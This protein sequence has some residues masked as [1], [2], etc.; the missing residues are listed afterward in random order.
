VPSRELPAEL[1]GVGQRIVDWFRL[2][3]GGDEPPPY[4]VYV[5][6]PDKEWQTRRGLGDLRTWLAAPGRGV[7]CV[8]VSLAGVFWQALEEGG[9]TEELFRQERATQH[10][11]KAQA[12]IHRA[13]AEVLRSPLPFS[14]RVE[15]AVRE[16]TPDP[17]AVFLYRA[18]TL[19]PIFRTSAL[20]EDLRPRLRVPVTLLYPGELRGEFGLRFMG[21]WEPTYNYRALIIDGTGETS[22]TAS[23]PA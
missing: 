6:P 19:Y 3:A 8:S 18:G 16:S 7:A 11:P 23:R 1:R 2:P 13:V 9:W 17:A 22:R 21:R 15:R 20:L 5:Y 14:Q 12:E 10:D 4:Q